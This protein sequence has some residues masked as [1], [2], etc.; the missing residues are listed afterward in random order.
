MCLNA[1]D[2][3]RVLHRWSQFV[4][5]SLDYV[6]LYKTSQRRGNYLISSKQLTY[7]DLE[8]LIKYFTSLLEI[9]YTYILFLQLMATQNGM[10]HVKMSV[11]IF[12][13]QMQKVVKKPKSQKKST[14]FNVI[15]RKSKTNLATMYM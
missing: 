2:K 10:L 4:C 3:Q 1:Q 14:I 12:L 11:F 9:Y 13:A 7:I 15:E 5:L 8:Y 6:P